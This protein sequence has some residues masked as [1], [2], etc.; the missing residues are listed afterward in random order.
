MAT[1]RYAGIGARATP[2]AVLADMTVMAGWLARTGWHLS[3]GGADGADTAFAAG[4]PVGQK[5]LWLPWRGYNGRSARECRVLSAAALEACMEIAAPLHPAWNRCS[6]A[7]R[8]LH[9]RNAAVLL[10]EALDRPVDA[11]VAWS[12]GGRIEGGTGM[13]IRIAE[14]RGIPVFNLGAM[15][16]R[17]VCERL[18]EIRRAV[19]SA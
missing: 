12:P 15:A 10:G 18:A 9:A 7:V 6:P 13:A 5:T 11:C 3:S 17:A 14:A 8:K 16:P 19:P 4:A 2:A 1:W